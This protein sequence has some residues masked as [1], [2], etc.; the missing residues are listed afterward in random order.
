MDNKKTVNSQMET[1][2]FESAAVSGVG[3]CDLTTKDF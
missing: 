1:F 3:S 2:A